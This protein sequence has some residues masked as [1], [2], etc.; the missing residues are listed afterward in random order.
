MDDMYA[1]LEEIHHRPEPFQHDTAA[2]LW[3]D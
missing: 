3:T 1:R 2:D